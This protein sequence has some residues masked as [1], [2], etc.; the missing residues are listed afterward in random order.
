MRETEG[1]MSTELEKREKTPTPL[2][3]NRNAGKLKGLH[4]CSKK[5]CKILTVF[6]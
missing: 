3:S 6:N 4:F 5:T 2:F 1:S